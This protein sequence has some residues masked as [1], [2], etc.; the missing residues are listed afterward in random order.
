V[1]IR[2]PWVAARYSSQGEARSAL[3]SEGG[4]EG[5]PL[6]LTPE[7]WTDDG[8]WFRTGD[9]AVVDEHGFVQL[10]D[11]TADLIK[12]GGEWIASQSIENR[13]MNHPS[14]REA[15][16]I[17][18]PDPKW[19]ERPLAVLAFKEGQS[20]TPEVLRAFVNEIFPKF[21]APDEFVIVDS[22]PRTSAG[23]F[24]KRALRAQYRA[25]RISG[26]R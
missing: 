13:L 17:G 19:S 22:L 6:Q 12:S 7:R 2:A 10:V 24:D 15:A 20:A 8:K 4:R 21:W 5:P 14:V 9:V 26:I 18:V 25:T 16:V 1:L 11:R 23:K 3:P